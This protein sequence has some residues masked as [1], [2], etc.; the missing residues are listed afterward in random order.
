MVYSTYVQQRILYFH[1]QGLRPYAITE[2]L[3][4]EEIATTRQGVRNLVKKYLLSG[5]IVR[6]PGSGSG[7]GRRTKITMDIK[8]IVDSQMQLHD[9][10][11]AIQLHHILRERGF[12]ISKR[13]T[14]RC[15]ASLGWTFR[16]TAYCQMIRENNKVKRLL[17]A[18]ENM[19]M[20][21]DNVIW[22]DETSIQ[23]E[24]HRRFCCRK[25]GQAAKPKPRYYYHSY[26]CNNNNYYYFLYR[27]KHPVKVHVWA[28]IKQE[29]SHANLYI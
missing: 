16:G 15:R 8:R 7:S 17:W 25:L 18:Q 9:E 22:T 10:T 3:R 27:P 19:K 1:F 20:E 29:R 21:F 28:G 2:A 6:R 14:L 24:T 12:N 4:R 5:S 13:T 11:T 23:L 26:C